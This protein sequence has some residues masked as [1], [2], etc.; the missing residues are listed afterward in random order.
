MSG[1]Q[2]LNKERYTEENCNGTFVNYSRRV[3]LDREYA[4]DEIEDEY[5]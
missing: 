2:T 3:F 4:V 1:S 5:L